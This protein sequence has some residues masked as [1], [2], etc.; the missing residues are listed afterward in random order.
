M[1]TLDIALA[2]PAMMGDNR[3]GPGSAAR[4]GDAPAMSLDA[5]MESLIRDAR[6]G[7]EAAVARIYELFKRQVFALAYRHTSSGA[8][9]EDILQDVFLKVFTHLG[10]IQNVR[11]FPAWVYRIALNACYSHLRRKKARGGDAISLRAIEGRREEAV[12]DTHEQSVSG[13]LE[14]SL[15]E[16]PAGLRSVFI[17]HDVQGFKHEEIARLLGCS[18]GTSKSQLFKARLKLR[19]S[20]RKRQAA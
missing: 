17:L 2:L 13:P 14:E 19:D 8:A 1:S 5:E 11:T 9:A 12:F 18:A 10:D 20:L 15:R 6:R 16:L 4:W 3:P 7:D